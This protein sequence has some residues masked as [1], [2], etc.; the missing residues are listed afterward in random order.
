MVIMLNRNT[1]IRDWRPRVWENLGWHYSAQLLDGGGK[2]I[3]EIY[4]PISPGTTYWA[5]VR[6]G[7]KQF[8]AVARTGA[9]AFRQAV[10][11]ATRLAWKIGDDLRRLEGKVE[12]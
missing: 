3:A 2:M 8:T 4:T 1:K 9:D 11:D 5:D 12:T 6:L 10:A 7:D